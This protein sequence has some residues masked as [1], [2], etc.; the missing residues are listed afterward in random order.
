[1]RS[2][3]WTAK[4]A[5]GAERGRIPDLTNQ[6]LALMLDPF[7]N[8]RGGATGGAGGGSAIGFAPAGARKPAARDRARLCLDPQQGAAGAELRS[9]VDRVGLGLRGQQYDERRY[10]VV[11]SS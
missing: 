10:A 9:A 11:G 4:S 3:N 6:F 2:P 7:V 5:T 1:M 8:G